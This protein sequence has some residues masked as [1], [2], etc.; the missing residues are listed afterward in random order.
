MGTDEKAGYQYLWCGHKWPSLVSN[1]SYEHTEL[2]SAA[3]VSAVTLNSP[4]SKTARTVHQAHLSSV[5]V[6]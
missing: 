3:I 6:P 2:H 5:D 1:F 4:L